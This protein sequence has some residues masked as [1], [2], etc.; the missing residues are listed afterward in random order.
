[1]SDPSCIVCGGA[2]APAVA[3]PRSSY[4]PLGSYRIDACGGCG[5]GATI[6]RPTADELARCYEATYSYSTHDLIEAEKRRR[7]AALLAWSGAVTGRILDVGCMFGFLLDEARGRG[8]VSHG[9]ELS[10]GAAA[11]A[12][13]RGHDVFA[14]TIEDFARDRPGLRFD[15][16]FAQHVLE[17]VPDPRGFLATAR[18]LLSPGGKLVLC[19]PNFEARLRKV[20]RSGWGWYQVP[21]HLHHFSSRALHRLLDDA[22]LAVEAERTRGGDTLFLMLS[23]LQTL[24]VNVGSSTA[25][26]QPGLARTALRVL[27]EVTRPYYALGDDELAVIARA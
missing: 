11:A 5:A 23:A 3:R 14:G 21:V 17:H 13:A 22:G 27:G 7:A 4:A 24:G 26:A 16:I 6:P 12:T 18:A 2:L 25:S 19:V 1:M 9:I 10:A 20:A 8:L 15:A